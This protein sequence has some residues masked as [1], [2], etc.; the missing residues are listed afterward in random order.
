MLSV[1]INRKTMGFLDAA[2]GRAVASLSGAAGGFVGQRINALAGGTVDAVKGVVGF[3][4]GLTEDEYK[5][6]EVGVKG[7]IKNIGGSVRDALFAEGKG[8]FNLKGAKVSPFNAKGILN[9][10]YHMRKGVAGASDVMIEGTA[11][12]LGII[13]KRTSDAAEQVLRGGVR[14]YSWMLG[15]I[16]PYQRDH[17]LTDI[18]LAKKA[19]DKTSGAVRN[20]LNKGLSPAPDNVRDIRSARKATAKAANATVAT[21]KAGGGAAGG[22]AEGLK[23]TA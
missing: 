4:K 19:Q 23:K 6:R 2:K 7:A 12:A 22:A 15:D 18:D 13:S 9:P 1:I 17:E 3:G 11:G 21:A 8:V 20:V 10:L 16:G 14:A 5:E